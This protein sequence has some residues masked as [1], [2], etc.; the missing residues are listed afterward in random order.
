MH[1]TIHFFV[2]AIKSS[3]SQDV[4]TLDKS[5][6]LSSARSSNVVRINCSALAAASAPVRKRCGDRSEVAAALPC[7]GCHSI[8]LAAIVVPR[9]KVAARPAHL[10]ICSHT[11]R[12]RG[13]PNT[14][15]RSRPVGRLCF[16]VPV[17]LAVLVRGR[18]SYPSTHQGNLNLT[19]VPSLSPPELFLMLRPSR[20]RVNGYLVNSL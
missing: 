5:I 1:R 15:P 6:P 12:H 16:M 3:V 2:R 7:H 20:R 18:P 19:V 8:T 13:C 9:M 4:V 11:R 17:R 14:T 10:L